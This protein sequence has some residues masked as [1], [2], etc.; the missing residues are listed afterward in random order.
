[1]L[2]EIGM[3]AS[4]EFKNKKTKGNLVFCNFKYEIFSML[5]SMYITSQPNVIMDSQCDSANASDENFILRMSGHVEDL[6]CGIQI[7]KW[8]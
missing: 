6:Y 5:M 8:G 2:V 1:M 4:T 3:L 7:A